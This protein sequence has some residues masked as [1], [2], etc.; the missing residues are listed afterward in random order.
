MDGEGHSDTAMHMLRDRAIAAY[1]LK[2]ERFN[3]PRS[4]VLGLGP[5]VGGEVYT[6]L[7][8]DF[9]PEGADGDLM[10]MNDP[11]FWTKATP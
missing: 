3:T 5:P 10:D 4:N 11:D 8:K 1:D 2:G 9:V 6:T 7:P